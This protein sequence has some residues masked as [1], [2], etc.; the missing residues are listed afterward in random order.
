MTQAT[1]NQERIE[2]ESNKGEVKNMNTIKV[3]LGADGTLLAESQGEKVSI[4]DTKLPRRFSTI[5]G[6]NPLLFEGAKVMG[7]FFKAVTGAQQCSNQLAD[8]KEKAQD[9]TYD[10]GESDLVFETLSQLIEEATATMQEVEDML[11]TLYEPDEE[12]SLTPTQLEYL[13]NSQLARDVLAVNMKTGIHKGI[14]IPGD[15][16]KEIVATL[17]DLRE[18]LGSIEVI[19]YPL[20]DYDDE[21]DWEDDDYED[22]WNDWEEDYDEEDYDGE[23]MDFDDEEESDGDCQSAPCGGEEEK[24]ES[25]EAPSPDVEVKQFDSLSDVLRYIGSMM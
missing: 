7:A 2:Q 8:Y 19:V 5:T 25:P 20:E 14:I 22:D 18:T 12:V 17:D 23:P 16:V 24:E 4:F 3:T 15:D 6:G 11:A 1:I 13:R 21:E 10:G 9:F